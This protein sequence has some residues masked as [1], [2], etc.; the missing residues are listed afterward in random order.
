MEKLTNFLLKS[1]QSE[2]KLDP[3]TIKSTLLSHFN[4]FLYAFTFWLQ[5]PVLPYLSKSLGSDGASFG[6][7]YSSVSFIS[8]LGGPLIGSLI[9][10]KGAKYG[11]LVAQGSSCLM[12]FFMTIAVF[13]NSLKSL[14]FSRI[15]GAGQHAMMCCQASIGSFV[16][17][18]KRTEALGM[19]SLS[20]GVGMLFGSF[21]G[22]HFSNYIGFEGVCFL[23]SLFSFFGVILDIFYFPDLKQK[24]SKKETKS[25]FENWKILKQKKVREVLIFSSLMSLSVGIFRTALS[26]S[27]T[28]S[29]SLD[30]S[31]MGEYMS[32][33]AFLG[34]LTNIFLVKPLIK[35]FNYNFFSLTFISILLLNISSY[36]MKFF[37]DS[38]L[39][40]YA[41]SIP[42]SIGSTLF[43]TLTT[44]MLSLCGTDVDQGAV[45]SLGHSVR[46]LVGLVS[47]ILGGFLIDFSGFSLVVNVTI[48]ISFFALSLMKILFSEMKK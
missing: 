33:I 32:I 29:S 17:P 31:F 6:L 45:T 12:Y 14:F 34:L 48:I 15:F 27:L 41:V 46:A 8:F 44:S 11:L 18:E 10:L 21:L 38:K 19:L 35:M 43:Y 26:L 23:A 16:S 47:P 39:G 30:P 40:I 28:E 4:L 9:D 42:M 3:K 2:T 1:K 20:Y 24:S 25:N 13:Q 37:L 5:Q 22:G 7:L 36:G